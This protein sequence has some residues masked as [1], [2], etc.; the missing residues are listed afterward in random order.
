MVGSGFAGLG[1]AI[2][3]ARSGER[4]V[5]VLERADDVGGTWRENTY[6]GCACDVPSVLYSFSF[7]PNRSWTRS[8][9]PQPEIQA[10]LQKVA[11]EYGVVPYLR[12]SCT[13]LDAQWDDSALVWRLR[14][15][16][17]DLTAQALVAAT[18]PLNEPALPRIRGLDRF[19]GELFHSAEWN[20]DYDLTGKRVAVIGTG[21]SAV[22]FIPHVARE[23]ARLTVFQRTAPWVMPRPDRT[24]TRVERRAYRSVPALQKL[25]R[26][27]V[28]A[29]REL[30]VIGF[31]NPGIMPLAERIASRHLRRQVPDPELRAKLTPHF[32][33]G[34][35]RVLL[36]NDY[37]PAL[38][39]RH[40]DLSTDPIAEVTASSVMSADGTERE[41]D[42]IILGTGFHVTDV[43]LA[44][45]VRNAAGVTLEEHWEGSPQ[46]HLGMMVDGYP[47]LFLMVGPNTG[48][49]HTSILLMIE[50]QASY[51]AEAVTTMRRRDLAAVEVRREV[52][53]R[54]NAALAQKLEGTVWTSGGCSSWYVD[55][56]GRVSTL[57]PTFTLPYMRSAQHFDPSTCHLTAR[58][59]QRDVLQSA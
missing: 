24:L 1:A 26:A 9:S 14:T 6:P 36:S 5:V 19:Q 34:C 17:G 10:Y 4:D 38:T 39:Q 41:V 2:A 21:A 12:T 29:S 42:C 35:K 15:S 49:G 59:A 25:A 55:A 18:G 52:L 16:R 7:A 58:T 31:R 30:S 50:A 23:A 44:R 45:Q 13:M 46:A 27:G 3:L 51:I 8:F 11:R 33:M 20:H 28:W 43:P 40:V 22:Q 47:N 54:Y 53:D 48:L 57:W 56:T 37:Y 32:R